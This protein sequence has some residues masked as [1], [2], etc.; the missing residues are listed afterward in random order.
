MV[1]KDNQP[2]LKTDLETLF[3]R[4][5]LSTT[6]IDSLQRSIESE[7]TLIG[8]LDRNAVRW[9]YAMCASGVVCLIALITAV[10]ILI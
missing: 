7:T 5:D 3:A 10:V 9:F 4:Y 6:T 2:T 8:L 1:V